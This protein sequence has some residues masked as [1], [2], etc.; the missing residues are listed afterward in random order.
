[1]AQTAALVRMIDAAGA[2]DRRT[3]PLI[4]ALSRL[5]CGVGIVAWCDKGRPAGALV[6]AITVLS[7][8]PPRILFCLPKATPEHNSL[9]EAD[10]CSINLLT[11]QD[12]AM[13]KTFAS[14]EDRRFDPAAWSMKTPD[15]PCYRSA[16]A[17]LFGNIGARM[18]AGTHSAFVVNL[19]GAELHEG[20]P[21]VAFNHGYVRIQDGAAAP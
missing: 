21:L 17:V 15:P 5:A 19:G 1:M 9:L 20:G 4:E 13:A 3:A 8:A 11:G 6:E 7:A 12:M 10:V 2:A 16:L 14:G 18:D